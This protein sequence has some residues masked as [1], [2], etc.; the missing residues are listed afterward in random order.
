MQLVQS[1]IDKALPRPNRHVNFTAGGWGGG[2]GD[3]RQDDSS[4]DA[5]WSSDS[6]SE[7]E[8]PP[9]EDT[10]TAYTRDSRL[11]RLIRIKCVTQLALLP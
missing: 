6:D 1:Y 4:R 5:G 9:D 8:K 11:K 2:G 10:E 3:E 7:A